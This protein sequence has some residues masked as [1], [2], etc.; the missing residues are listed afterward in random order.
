MAAQRPTKRRSNRPLS[1]LREAQRRPRLAY[2][3]KTSL[4]FAMCF[5]MRRAPSNH[6]RAG[7]RSTHNVS[8]LSAFSLVELLVS[9]TVFLILMVMLLTITGQV[10]GIWSSSRNRIDVA[11]AVRGFF[12]QSQ[13]ELTAALSASPRLVGQFQLPESSRWQFVQNPIIPLGIRLPHTDSIFFQTGTTDTPRGNVSAVGY[14]VNRDRQLIR[15]FTP[16]DIDTRFQELGPDPA[17]ILNESWTE[18]Q[19]PDLDD[20]NPAPNWLN[21][22]LFPATSFDPRVD[23]NV[24]KAVSVLAEGIAGFWIRCYDVEGRP[25]PF[26]LVAPSGGANDRVKFDSNY[27]PTLRRLP[28]SL[29]ITLALF[30]PSTLQRFSDQIT[31]SFPEQ[32]PIADNSDPSILA[33]IDALMESC[34]S[35]GVPAPRLFRARFVIPPGTYRRTDGGY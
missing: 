18:T 24:S 19:S 33:S 21:P 10:Q 30:E 17:Y 2:A 28:G 6:K 5:L 7:S 12:L 11:Q 3:V 32:L 22:P 29:E 20:Y 35:A 25:I 26:D 9:M 8:S 31:E 14:F 16:M 15:L 13:R 23:G 27:P 4:I 1:D 34:L